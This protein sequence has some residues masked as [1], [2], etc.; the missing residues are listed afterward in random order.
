MIKTKK[1][2]LFVIN[3]LKCGGAEKALISLLQ[4]M[5][6]SKFDVD[7]LLFK[8]EGLFLNQVPSNVNLLP[9]PENYQFFDMSLKN[10]LLLNFK[11]GN[12]KIAFYRLM[13]GLIYRVEK[14]ASVKEQRGWRYLK[15][16]LEQIPKE[17]DVAIGFL[18]KNPNYFC[19]DK[20]IAKKKIAFVMNDYNQLKMDKSIDN[21]Y[22]SKFDHIAQDSVESNTVMKT[23]FPQFAHKM[24]V[25][26]SIISTSSIQQLAQQTIPIITPEIKII[27]IGRLTYQKGYDI[28]IDAINLLVERGLNFKWIILGDGDK[29][30]EL[31]KKVIDYSL[32]DRVLFLGV[33]ENHYPYLQQATIFLH[34]ARFEGFGIVISEAKIL[35]KPMVLTNFNVARTHIK[36]GTTGLIAEM[37]PE[38]V[39]DKLE[40]LMTN[41]S[42]QKEFSY[43]LGLQNFGTENEI[44]MFYALIE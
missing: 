32:Q 14:T 22:F 24:V 44:E 38:D 19:I 31:E 37:N 2:L 35:K 10:A 43:N 34:T 20:V 17:Y 39:A 4:T 27:S 8:Q 12:F 40:V 15:K 23:V 28:A 11:R 5:D 18:E 33:K 3:N 1:K 7:L 21:C 41:T 13:F 26:K 6:Y 9:V 36:D 29:K 25:I 42:L 16:V 30:Q